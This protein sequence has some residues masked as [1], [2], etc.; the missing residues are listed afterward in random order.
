[1]EINNFPDKN[2]SKQQLIDDYF[3]VFKMKTLEKYMTAI[4]KD[5]NFKSIITYGSPRLPM[6]NVKGFFLYLQNRESK[7]YK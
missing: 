7:M 4:K 1:M 5:E 6:I 3:P 2:V